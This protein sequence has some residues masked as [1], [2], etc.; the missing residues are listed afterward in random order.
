MKTRE[1]ARLILL[2]EKNRILLMKI[3]DKTVSDPVN[4]IQRPF[5]ITPGGKI[6]PGEAPKEAVLR[7]LYEETGISHAEVIEPAAWYGEIILNMR[8][9]KVLC[10]ESFFITRLQ[11]TKIT[12]FTRIPQKRDGANCAQVILHVFCNRNNARDL[13]YI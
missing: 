3:W 11:S 1:T 7:E 2:D 5:W 8:G 10:K 4:P 9:E 13:G 12:L 6:E